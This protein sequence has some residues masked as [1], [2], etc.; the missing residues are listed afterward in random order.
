MFNLLAVLYQIGPLLL[1]PLWAYHESNWWLLIGIGV[2]WVASFSAASRSKLFFLFA[3]LCIG[4]WIHS[5]FSIYQYI[6]FY[7]FCALWGYM[8]FQMAEV[9]EQEYATCLI[10]NPELFDGRWR[11]G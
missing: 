8:F 2:S 4:L 1:I 6:T 3:C 7:F 10:E 9:A 11:G 5:G